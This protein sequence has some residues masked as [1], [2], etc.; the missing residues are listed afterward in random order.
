MLSPDETTT[1]PAADVSPLPTITLILPD[2]PLVAVPERITNEPV[3]PL[4]DVPVFKAKLPDTPSDPASELKTV[5]A[6]LEL[7]VPKPVTR[8]IEPPVASV[9]SPELRTTLAPTKLVPL[10]AITLTLPLV[11]P[12]ADP[13]RITIDPE[14]PSDEVPDFND[15]D[16]LVPLEPASDV[17]NENAPL[18]DTLP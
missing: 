17:S 11:P 1:R 10:P 4:E 2:V 16:P 3:D 12:V 15:N 8:D 18:D 13:E 14:L 5:N 7:A 6:P 9:L